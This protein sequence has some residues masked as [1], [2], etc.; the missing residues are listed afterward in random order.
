MAGLDQVYAG[1]SAVEQEEKIAH[2]S[3]AT[4]SHRTPNYFLVTGEGERVTA[5]RFDY[6]NHKHE[7]GNTVYL[8]ANWLKAFYSR[9]VAFFRDRA[10]HVKEHLQAEMRGND[11]HGP[12]GNLGAIGW[13]VD[14]MAFVKKNDPIFYGAIQGK[15]RLED[16]DVPAPKLPPLNLNQKSTRRI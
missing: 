11:D 15:Y 4:S 10:G 12:G 6:G 3:G 8:E 7:F 9:D 2:A 13:F 14:V 5:E 16:A 1:N